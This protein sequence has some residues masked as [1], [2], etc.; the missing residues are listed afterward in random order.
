MLK[1]AQEKG[2]LASFEANAQRVLLRGLTEGELQDVEFLLKDDKIRAVLMVP[3]NGV[4]VPLGDNITHL[5]PLVGGVQ[6]TRI[7]GIRALQREGRTTLLLGAD[8]KLLESWGALRRDALPDRIERMIQTGRLDRADFVLNEAVRILGKDS[9]LLPPL[10][11][12]FASHIIPAVEELVVRFQKGGVDERYEVYREALPI[13]DKVAGYA[14]GVLDTGWTELLWRELFRSTLDE[15]E[16]AEREGRNFTAAIRLLRAQGLDT[17]AEPRAPRAFS[18]ALQSEDRGLFP[19]AQNL[20]ARAFLEVVPIFDP[21][22]PGGAAANQVVQALAAGLRL[23]QDG[24]LKLGNDPKYDELSKPE[25]RP[26]Y[27]LDPSPRAKGAAQPEAPKAL[28][29]A[30]NQSIQKISAPA[31]EKLPSCQWQLDE[32]GIGL[33]LSCK[34]APKSNHNPAVEKALGA[35]ALRSL[36]TEQQRLQKQSSPGWSG[37]FARSVVIRD[38]ILDRTF[39]QSAKIRGV[40]K[41]AAGSI[42]TALNARL[43][44]DLPRPVSALL[45]AHL[46]AWRSGLRRMRWSKTDQKNELKWGLYFFSKDEGVRTDLGP[47]Q[48]QAITPPGRASEEEAWKKKH[49]LPVLLAPKPAPRG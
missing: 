16:R 44:R 5:A 25:A 1:R 46:S 37:R 8:D 40:G 30:V 26:L 3:K 32:H 20:L 21:Q 18:Q 39:E 15:A 36:H 29:E 17:R 19:R 23:S 10:V 45:Q 22:K 7:S 34:P 31:Q 2:E 41:S 4:N 24:L 14:G 12:P 43:V 42:Q 38:G 27:W 9:P 48:V 49:P 33:M 28:L 35:L 47:P 11:V 6:T 13:A